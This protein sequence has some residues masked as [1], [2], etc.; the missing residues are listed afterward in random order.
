M[1][2]NQA[3]YHE[4]GESFQE[5]SFSPKKEGE[6][7]AQSE[8]LISEHKATFSDTQQLPKGLFSPILT[9]QIH[10]SEDYN[11]QAAEAQDR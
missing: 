11:I 2:L 7:E 5:N 9:Q 3:K 8:Q 10:Q 6:V 1:Q 4:A